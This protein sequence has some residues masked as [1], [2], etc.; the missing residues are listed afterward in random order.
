MDPDFTQWEK[1]RFEALKA[2][3]GHQYMKAAQLNEEM[4]RINESDTK[5]NYNAGLNYVRVNRPLK[6]LEILNQF[7]QRCRDMNK[8]FSWADVRFAEAYFKLGMYDMTRLKKSFIAFPHMINP[9]L[10]PTCSCP[11]PGSKSINQM[12]PFFKGRILL[13]LQDLQ[14]DLLQP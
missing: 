14:L 8:N 3:E 5:A 6:V 1:L 2:S 11:F 13:V 9:G 10:M 4:F 12:A 7:D